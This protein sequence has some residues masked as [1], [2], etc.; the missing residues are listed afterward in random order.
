MVRLITF[1][2]IFS[3]LFVNAQKIQFKE[4]ISENNFTIY[5]K[6]KLILID[7]WATWCAPCVIATKQLEIFQD[8]LK[9]KVY[10]I[11]LTDETREVVLNKLNKKNINL[12]VYL[13]DNKQTFTY[14]KIT[15]RPYAVIL[16]YNG[17]KLWEGHPGDLTI[18][19]INQFHDKVIGTP[20]KNALDKLIQINEEKS[21]VKNFELSIKSSEM[22]DFVFEINDD[23][24]YINGSVKDCI[25]LLKDINT[26]QLEVNSTDFTEISCD[27][28]TW[29]HQKQLIIDGVLSK[30]N[31]KESVSSKEVEVENLIVSNKDLLWDTNQI[32]WGNENLAQKIVDDNRLQANN[33]TINQLAILLSGLKNR[34]FYFSDSSNTTH[35]W[36]L[37]YLYDELMYEELES[38]YGIEIKKTIKNIPFYVFN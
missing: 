21:S 15:Q 33:Y 12:S 14:F 34:P 27:L 13:D 3:S 26:Y 30:F 9:D 25:S 29:I 20:K 32:N 16:D 37:H 10:M 19:K 6:Q 24:V 28:N 5:D 18:D 36:D 17:E 8:V 11:A 7:F 31:L 4:K 2:L 22:T 38:S 1:L 35:D 23:H